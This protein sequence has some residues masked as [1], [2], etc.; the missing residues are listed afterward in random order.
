MM[1]S[2][3]PI[4]KLVSVVLALASAPSAL[5]F[6]ATLEDPWNIVMADTS[7]DISWPAVNGLEINNACIRGDSFVSLRPIRSCS[8]VEVTSR[9]ACRYHGE[10]ELCRNLAPGENAGPFEIYREESHCTAY[11]SH[12]VIVPRTYSVTTCVKWTRPTEASNGECLEFETHQEYAPSSYLVTIYRT[13]SQESGP[14]FMGNKR[15]D[16]PSCAP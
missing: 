3:L 16:I 8:A 10:A 7:L 13:W 4:L 6:Y 12:T 2:L 9:Q 14:Q 11:E 5:A 15:F 1:K